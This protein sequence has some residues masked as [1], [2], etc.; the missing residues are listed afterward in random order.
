ML[1]RI[2]NEEIWYDNDYHMYFLSRHTHIIYYISIFNDIPNDTVILKWIHVR[3]LPICAYIYVDHF[4]VK[5][6]IR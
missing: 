2:P 4:S 1:V 6:E 5:S 3:K